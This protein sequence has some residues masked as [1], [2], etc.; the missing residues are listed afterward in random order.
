MGGSDARP[1]VRGSGAGATISCCSPIRV[2]APRDD[3]EPETERTEAEKRAL[4]TASQKKPAL[5][6]RV[7]ALMKA[8][9]AHRVFRRWNRS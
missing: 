6:Y 5:R 8:R 2:A 3:E 7:D 1:D 4:P 9:I